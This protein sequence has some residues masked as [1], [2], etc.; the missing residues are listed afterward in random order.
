MILRVRARGLDHVRARVLIRNLALCPDELET[1]SL[2][3]KPLG[4]VGAFE[5]ALALLSF[6]G[7]RFSFALVTIVPAGEIF[8]FRNR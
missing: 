1:K 2:F 8:D 5:I 6:P 4:P 7:D 3:R